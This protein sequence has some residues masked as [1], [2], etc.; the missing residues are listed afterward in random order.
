[1]T[2]DGYVFTIDE[3]VGSVFTG[4]T[5]KLKA[6][7]NWIGNSYQFYQS[8]SEVFEGNAFTNGDMVQSKDAFAT[9]NGSGWVGSLKYVTPGQGL[10]LNLKKA[11]DV[12]LKGENRM[13]QNYTQPAGARAMD[14]DSW[15]LVQGS[16]FMDNVQ[17]STVGSRFADNMAMIAQV[18][19]VTDPLRTTIFALVDD[20]C[21]GVSVADADRLFITIHGNMGETVH[22]IAYDQL[23]GLY[24]PINNQCQLS[25]M[26][27]TLDHPFLLHAS[28]ATSVDP[29]MLSTGQAEEIYDLQGRKLH[30][31][32]SK[33]GKGIYIV[34]PAGK[35][36][37][38][39]VR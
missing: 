39:M 10:L 36:G 15:L 20:E 13:K 2:N 1:V 3:N 19:G 16:Q 33:P 18:D 34:R 11:M 26:T 22:F 32:A 12:K 23:T 25:P 30:S 35:N 28:D 9:W 21:R 14:D 4:N 6:G 7:W 31:N 8:I 29:V 37:K 27:G 5:L 38:K 17:R 24:H